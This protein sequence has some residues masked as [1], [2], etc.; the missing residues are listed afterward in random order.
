MCPETKREKGKGKR[1]IVV[2]GGFAGALAARILEKQFDVVLI[3]TKDYFEFTPGI[4][5]VI[6]EPNHLP[7]IQARH[8]DYL[9]KARFV[10]SRAREITDREIKTAREVLGFDYAIIACG[11]RYNQPFK[12]KDVVISTRG[13]HLRE[14]AEKTRKAKRIAIIGGGIVGVEL[15]GELVEKYPEKSI[16]LIHANSEL[17]ERTPK[18]AREY[19]RRFLTEK[20]VR[21][22]FRERVIKKNGKKYVTD[23][24]RVV[25]ADLGFLCTGIKPN[26]ECISK[27]IGE[28]LTPTGFVKVNEFLQLE[29]CEN[30]FG[31]GDI[32]GIKE[33][34][35]AQTAEI[36]ARIAAKNITRLEQGKELIRYSAGPRIMVISLGKKRGIVT[37]K[38]F[39]ATGIIAGILKHLV[40]IKAMWKYKRLSVIA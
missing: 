30:I 17:M 36:H 15:A 6:V 3:D 33:E 29:G 19:A 7:K 10:K 12:E 28:C 2:G 25:E 34:K 35:T 22:I 20:G 4:L 26:S 13:S 40:E 9:K 39:V 32:T 16:T 24:G 31:A 8:I 1:V 18:K 38:S 37:Y 5:R 27:K 23:K 14:Y 21:I 11:S